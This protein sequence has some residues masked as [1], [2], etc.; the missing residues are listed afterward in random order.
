MQRIL[1]PTARMYLAFDLWLEWS[2][3]RGLPSACNEGLRVATCNPVL[4]S[5]IWF[6]NT[7]SENIGALFCRLRGSPALLVVRN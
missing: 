4:T 2:A 6:L 3:L 5:A 7:G 1:I